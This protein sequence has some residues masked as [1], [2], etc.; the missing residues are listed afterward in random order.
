[1]TALAN[2]ANNVPELPPLVWLTSVDSTNAQCLRQ[3]PVSPD[4]P[5]CIVL[6]TDQQT[7]GRGRRGRSWSS[8]PGRSLCMSYARQLSATPEMMSL[9]PLAV[10]YALGQFFKTVGLPVKLKWPNDVLALGKKLAGLLCES[11]PMESS[12]WV[13]VGLGINIR[14]MQVDDALD[15]AGAIALEQICTPEQ[16]AALLDAPA[17]AQALAE[18]IHQAITHLLDHGLSPWLPALHAMDPWV[19]QTVSVI[20]QGQVQL[21]GL[22]LGVDEHGHYLLQTP[23]G[24]RSVVSGDL[25]L[26]MA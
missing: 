11:M 10:G 21:Q 6:A 2:A 7:A 1:M 3:L 17:L 20:E 25:S 19:G 9:I 15:G 23:T 13:I 26:R 8:E 16:A 12:H 24:V 4:M 5:R 14:S 18:Q 22:A